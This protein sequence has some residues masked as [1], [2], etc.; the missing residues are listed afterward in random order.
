MIENVDKRPTLVIVEDHVAVRQGLAALL[1]AGG[2]ELLGSAGDVEEAYELVGATSPDVVVADVKLGS[3]SGIDL[4]ARLLDRNPELGVLM[5]TGAED[6][7][8][9]T[10]ALDIGARGFALK[11]GSAQELVTAARRVA[12]GG[13]Y[14]D[15][16]LRPLLLARDAT[17]KVAELTPRER[18][19]LAMLAE[20]HTAREAAKLLGIGDETV[21]THLRNAMDK[22]EARTRVHAIAIALRDQR[23]D[24]PDRPPDRPPA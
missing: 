22:L 2:F 6:P 16:R 24:V 19:V 5:Y 23:I 13:A 8:L 9:L 4:V 12:A 11:A 20:G 7:S 21:K 3:A 14:V 17:E 10:A 15:P 1:R 18:D